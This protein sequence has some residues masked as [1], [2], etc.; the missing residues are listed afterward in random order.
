MPDA[1]AREATRRRDDARELLSGFRAGEPAEEGHRQKMLSLLLGPDD[2]FARDSVRDGHFTASAFVVHDGHLLLIWHRKL[3]RWLQ[4]GGH[5]DPEDEDL[6]AAATRELREETGVTGARCVR[7]LDVDVHPI[8]ANPKRG[9]PAHRHHDVRFLFEASSHEAVAGSDA[10]EVKWV[11]FA[12]VDA[13]LTDASVVR[14]VAK[15]PR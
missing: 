1:A 11:R 8:P 4:P 3:L 7:L 15:L 9:E 13:E 12:D 2:P 10:G 6:Q 5:V 14:A